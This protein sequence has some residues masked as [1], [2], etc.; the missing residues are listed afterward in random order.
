LTPTPGQ[1]APSAVP[2]TATMPLAVGAAGEVLPTRVNL[3]E[4][5]GATYPIRW[6][7]PRSTQVL[8]LGKDRSGAWLR[9]VMPD[10]RAGWMATSLVRLAAPLAS[11]PLVDGNPAGEAD[12]AAASA[13]SAPVSALP[14]GGVPEDSGVDT[15]AAAVPSISDAP[16]GLG[17]VIVPQTSLHIAPGSRTEVVQTLRADEQVKLFGQAKGAWVR[18]QPFSAVVPGWVYAAHLRPLPGTI[19]GAPVLTATATLSITTTSAP[20]VGTAP[21]TAAP[22]PTPTRAPAV[23]QALTEPVTEEPAPPL[24]PRV[25]VAITVDVVEASAAPPERRRGATPT[26]AAR[27]GVAGLRVEL[28]TAFGDVLVEAVTPATGRVT[29]T[30]DVPADTAL[31][32]QVPA[33]GLRTQLPPAEV[34]AGTTAVT[35]TVPPVTP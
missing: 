35:I 31:F 25:P 26:P 33:L 24:P 30:R 11:L 32:V 14:A 9:V 16:E 17:V 29:F 3:R 19:E 10:E 20:M 23:V 2:I 8:V 4:G 15:K 7:Y 18:V 22:P 13:A 6:S 12:G 21:G 5:P 28:V 27:S 1:V 34:A